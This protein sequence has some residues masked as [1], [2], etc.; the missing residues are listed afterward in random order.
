M[1]KTVLDEKER[2]TQI[3]WDMEELRKQCMEMESF[4]NSIKVCVSLSFFH[5]KIHL[6]STIDVF[7]YI[8]L[9]GRENTY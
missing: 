8:W 9:I 2:F 1:E 5:C 6:H 3:Q 7:L 4:L